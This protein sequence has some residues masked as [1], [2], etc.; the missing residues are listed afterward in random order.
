MNSRKKLQWQKIHL[1]QKPKQMIKCNKT[2]NK[3]D[4]FQ[5]LQVHLSGSVDIFTVRHRCVEMCGPFKCFGYLSVICAQ[6]SRCKKQCI[7]SDVTGW[8]WSVGPS[9]N[10]Y[11][12]RKSLSEKKNKEKKLTHD[13]NR[14]C[15]L[16]NYTPNVIAWQYDA[17]IWIKELLCD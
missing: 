5:D 3:S 9:F 13:N 16:L 8:W 1:K 14:P 11:C 4:P 17:Y 7:T 15:A 10:S 6:I 2:L 12:S